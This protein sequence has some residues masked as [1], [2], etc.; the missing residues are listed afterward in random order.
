MGADPATY[1]A[2][3]VMATRPATMPDAAPRLVGWPSRRHST[4][5][6]DK[7][8]AAA[9]RKVLTKA[10]AAWPSAPSADP[11]LKPNHP[12]HRIP[13]PSITSGM[14][15]GRCGFSVRC[16]RTSTAAS[17]AIPALTWMAVPP[18]KSS[19]PRLPSH[20]PYTH[21]NTGT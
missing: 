12:N 17:A 2:P 5:T 13:V 7:P 6:Q 3:G 8:A 11:A 16:P 9:A 18:A 1:P 21:L 19:D 14:L 10:W 20:P 4:S 15:C